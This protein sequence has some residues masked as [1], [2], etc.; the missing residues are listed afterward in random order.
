MD[1]SSD[2]SLLKRKESNARH[3]PPRT[4]P[5]YGQVSRMKAMLFAVGCMALLDGALIVT[6]DERL[7]F[8]F[9]REQM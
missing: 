4:Q 5:D 1:D 8:F 2:M 9:G 3:Q 6:T 7:S